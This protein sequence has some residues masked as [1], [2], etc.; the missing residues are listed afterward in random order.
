MRFWKGQRG[1]LYNVSMWDD[2]MLLDICLMQS[3][4]PP[5]MSVDIYSPKE[6]V[7]GHEAM[8]WFQ[9]KHRAGQSLFDDGCWDQQ[10]RSW[11]GSGME[12]GWDMD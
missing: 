7:I 5:G 2:G 4:H 6:M 12:Y 11:T 8:A 1:V 10:A 9:Q 3:R